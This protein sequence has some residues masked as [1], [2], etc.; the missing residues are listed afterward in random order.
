MVR[1]G[2]R[3]KTIVEKEMDTGLGGMMAT[4]GD[5][6]HRWLRKQR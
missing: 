4:I 1:D 5:Q 3:H 6:K 2:Y